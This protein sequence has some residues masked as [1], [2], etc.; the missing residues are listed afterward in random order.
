MQVRENAMNRDNIRFDGDDITLA[1]K[2][3]DKLTNTI[4][5]MYYLMGR[6]EEEAFVV[7]LVSAQNIDLKALLTKEKRDT[8]ILFEIDKEASVYTIICQGTKIDGGYYFGERVLHKMISEKGDD[9]YCVELEVKTTAHNIKYV[10]FKLI[11][12]YIKT[13]QDKNEGE[14]IFKTLH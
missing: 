10:V 11:E 8:D 7:M 4:D 12:M 6:R 2:M 14:L 1:V 5:I 3:I 9:V 13:R